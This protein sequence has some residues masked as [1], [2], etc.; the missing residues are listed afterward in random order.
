MGN[1]LATTD[2][3]KPQTI[4]MLGSDQR[5]KDSHD[6]EGTD[7]RSDTIMLIR[8]DP[9]KEATAIMS[10]PRDLKVAIPGH[11]VEKINAAYEL[12]RRRS[13]RSRR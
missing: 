11:G 8:L 7:A 4:M 2:P 10:L 12:R 6:Y 13:S 9:S 5:A 1:E 3:G